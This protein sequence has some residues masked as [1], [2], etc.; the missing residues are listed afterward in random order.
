MCIFYFMPIN[1]FKFFTEYL[2]YSEIILPVT[3]IIYYLNYII[4]STVTLLYK[5][6]HFYNSAN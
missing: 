4:Y 2:H 5:N 6:K 3:I 1:T